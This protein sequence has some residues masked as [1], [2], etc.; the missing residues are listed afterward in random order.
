MQKSLRSYKN[1]LQLKPNH[2]QA[3]ANLGVVH[4]D[5][6][7]YR[8]AE[9][10]YKRSLLLHPADWRTLKNLGNLIFLRAKNEIGKQRRE[11][12]Q[13]ARLYFLR[14]LE[15]NR[16]F[17]DARI[18]LGKVNAMLGNGSSMKGK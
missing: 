14:S 1:A 18:A 4:Q 2:H 10:S 9:V 8:E 17:K 15:Y 3:H 12:L 13:E 16:N 7:Q 6:G 5:L 11:S